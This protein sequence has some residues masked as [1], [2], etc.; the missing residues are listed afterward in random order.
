MVDL[1]TALQAAQAAER[2]RDK[3]AGRDEKKKRRSGQ[4]LGIEPFDPVKYV[5]K[6]K[7]ETASMWL[8]IAFSVTVTLLMRYV[9]MP[10]TSVDN[11]DILYLLPLVMIILIPQIHRMVMPAEF[12]ELYTKGTWFKAAF[13]HTFTFLSVAF[14][15]VNPPF[16]DIVAPQLSS[17]WRIAVDD[18]GTFTVSDKASQNKVT[19]T[20]DEG[21]VLTGEAWIVF[22]LADNAQD[23]GAVVEIH[24]TCQSQDTILEP[25]ATFWG[26]YESEWSNW[27]TQSNGSTPTLFPHNGLDQQFAISLGSGLA[28]GQHTILVYI[29]EEGNPWQNT[30]TYSWVLD[31][32]SSSGN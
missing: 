17:E 28:V 15:L 30:R 25:N 12:V 9:L 26:T 23:D 7:A 13:L 2:R 20:L 22:G 29:T 27:T 18:D 1:S 31:I 5:K 10:S 24:H 14:L 32:Q 11:A 8:V 6:E 16:G 3:G 19:W 21:N 4:D